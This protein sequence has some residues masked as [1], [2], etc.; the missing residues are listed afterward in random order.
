MAA[1]VLN[2]SLPALSEHI[3]KVMYG[4]PYGPGV[5]L[6][7]AAHPAGEPAPHADL[8]P[9]SLETVEINV[10]E[11][12]ALPPGTI[13]YDQLP[14]PSDL[15]VVSLEAAVEQLQPTCSCDLWVSSELATP[16]KW[17]EG[18]V[19]SLAEK[20]LEWFGPN[21]IVN[22]IR[23]ERSLAPHEWFVECGDGRRVGSMAP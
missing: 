22:R 17:P 6:T 11:R 8:S 19:K 4:E 12:P 7:S 5:A 16:E 14:T 13:Q 15:G 21:F 18:N 23:I 9:E 10:P 2:T 3:H 20:V 1:D